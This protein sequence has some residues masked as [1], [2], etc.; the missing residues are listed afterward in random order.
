MS[1]GLTAL[2]TDSDRAA[3]A[4]KTT[5]EELKRLKAD[6]DTRLATFAKPEDVSSAVGPH[7]RQAGGA[8]AGRAGR[9]QERGRSPH[10]RRAHR[11][12]AGARQPEARHRSR[13]GVRARA[14]AGAQGCRHQRRPGAA[15][16]L[17]ARWRADVDRAARAVQAGRLQDHRR[18]GAAGRR[19][20]RRPP[21]RRRAVGGARA[22]DEPQPRRQEHRGGRRA[23]GDRAQR[24]SP[25]R[26]SRRGED[27]AAPA[28]D[29]A[30]DFLAKVQ[31]RDAVDRA[32]ASVET[33]LKASLA[34]APADAN[35]NA[36]Q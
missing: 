30:Q 31:A 34:A 21:A 22:Q 6:L 12:V 13:Q 9:H 32:L 2:K 26:R 33:Q 17:R 18:R 10:D 8:A 14:G 16:A 7:Q 19:L 20:D 24:G 4:L 35:A 25:R 5:Q 27:A 28:Q 1:T 36:A 15:G 11:S 29:A 23:H 3:A